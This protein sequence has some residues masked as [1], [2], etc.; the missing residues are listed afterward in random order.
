VAQAA[1]D[2][3]SVA[4]TCLSEDGLIS[5]TKTIIPRDLSLTGGL[6]KAKTQFSLPIGPETRFCFSVTLKCLS[7]KM[8][9]IIIDDYEI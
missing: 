4:S 9:I 3:Y 2:L 8:T 5:G 7:F 1:N 6:T